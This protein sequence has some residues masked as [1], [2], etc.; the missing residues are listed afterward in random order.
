MS[1]PIHCSYCNNS[2]GADGACPTCGHAASSSDLVAKA[3]A[4]FVSYL[5]ARI[6]HARQ[7]LKA[8]QRE[9]AG[10][11]R[12]RV[13]RD[14]VARAEDELERLQTQLVAQTRE[15]QRAQRA[16]EQARFLSASQSTETRGLP[17]RKCPRCDSAMP[18]AVQHCRCGYVVETSTANAVSLF[19][20][21]HGTVI[22]KAGKNK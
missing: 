5:A 18:G 20:Q 7:Q 15:A 14:A 8:A 2:L 11:P 9:A 4:L 10:D 13:R 17:E 1:P 6:V 12:S 22:D 21:E 16:V 19:P 3:E